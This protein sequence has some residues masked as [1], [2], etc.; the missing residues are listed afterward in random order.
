MLIAKKKIFYLSISV[1]I[2][3]VAFCPK[4]SVLVNISTFVII[5]KT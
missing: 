2:L 4:F 5:L 1:I 3:K